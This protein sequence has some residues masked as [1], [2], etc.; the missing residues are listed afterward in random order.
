MAE[1]KRLYHFM[2]ARYA[3]QAIERHRLKASDLDETNDPYEYLAIR[4][5]NPQEEE[6]FSNLRRHVAEN[7]SV[8]CLSETSCDPSL[9]GH[10]ADRLKGICL[11]FDAIPYDHDKRLT[12]HPHQVTYAK[13]RIDILE[14]GTCFVGGQLNIQNFKVGNVLRIMNVKSYHW[15]YEKEWRIWDKKTE[16]DPVTG[17]HFFPFCDQIKLREILIGFRCIEENPD[18][19][20]R[21]DKLVAC[22]SEPP[23]I[24][25]TRRSLSTF[26]IE[27]VPFQ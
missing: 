26:E 27:R 2:P 12:A 18:I 8:V 23:E 14:F 5:N 21:L 19:K 25:S 11:G 10:Y 22:Y 17:R 13:D 7:F 1:T 20:V 6:S 4:F 16:S 15:E 24:F 9:W 3:L